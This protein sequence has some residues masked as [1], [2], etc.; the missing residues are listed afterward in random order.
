METQTEPCVELQLAPDG[1]T[2]HLETRLVPG[3]MNLSV[4]E[5]SRWFGTILQDAHSLL[6]QRE[7][8]GDRQHGRLVKSGRRSWFRAEAPP[9]LLSS[10]ETLALDWAVPEPSASLVDL[11]EEVTPEEVSQALQAPPPPDLEEKEATP[12]RT[13]PPPDK[14]KQ[15]KALLAIL[16]KAGERLDIPTLKERSKLSDYMTRKTLKELKE[17]DVIEEHWDESGGRWGGKATY[18]AK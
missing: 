10:E 3:E 8:N 1:I 13:S 11:A 17:T 7:A 15:G 12:R 5:G 2:I 16:S 9:P 14:T 4:E 18:A 6:L